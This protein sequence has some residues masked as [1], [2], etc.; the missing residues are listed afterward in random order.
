MGECHPWIEQTAE[1]VQAWVG[2]GLMRRS[3]GFVE[4]KFKATLIPRHTA[5]SLCHQASWD[6]VGSY[7][8]PSP[9]LSATGGFREASEGT[10]Q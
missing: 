10:L 3:L 7:P 1:V 4:R 8:E 5:A 2:T 6:L 9:Y